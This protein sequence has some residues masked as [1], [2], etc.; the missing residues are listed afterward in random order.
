L[1][2]AR[3]SGHCLTVL[4]L[5]CCLAVAATR[6]APVAGDSCA[7]TIVA[8]SV[9]P[10]GAW[11]AVVDEAVCESGGFASAVVATV[12]LGPVKG[13]ARL[14]DLLGVD[15]GGHVEQRP[16]L[17]WAGDDVLRV[18]VANRSLL[19]ILAR[20]VG[21]VAVDVRFDPPDPEARATWL[22][23]LGLPPDD[24]EQR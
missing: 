22:R 8:T 18:T 24:R 5:G 7:H 10:D 19:K 17:L 1:I 16:R 6:A 3:H 11:R 4:V 13:P 23:S 9:S 21:P 14:T 15:T 12:G 20:G 2:L